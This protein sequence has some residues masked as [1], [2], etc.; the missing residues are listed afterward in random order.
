MRS[1]NKKSKLIISALSLCSIFS[2]GTVQA[3]VVEYG[4][5]PYSVKTKDASGKEVSKQY[6]FNWCTVRTEPKPPIDA[7]HPKDLLKIPV[8]TG[9]KSS[10]RNSIVVV[11]KAI[12]VPLPQLYT[13]YGKLVY[14]TTMRNKAESPLLGRSYGFIFAQTSEWGVKR[15]PRQENDE[16]SIEVSD[17]PGSD[18]IIDDTPENFCMLIKHKEITGNVFI[19]SEACNVTYHEVPNGEDAKDTCNNFISQKPIDDGKQAH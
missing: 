1:N 14:D 16:C 7:R 15:I 18:T 19:K 10:G 8:I 4:N 6:D 11:E 9:V 17:R 13:T 12:D 3:N 5:C 2:L